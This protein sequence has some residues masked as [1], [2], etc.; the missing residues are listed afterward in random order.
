MNFMR[1]VLSFFIFAFFIVTCNQSSS[2][3]VNENNLKTYLLSE[4]KKYD[5]TYILQTFTFI[6]LD[7]ITLQDQY[8]QFINGMLDK[9]EENHIEIKRLFEE[10]KSN[11][12]MQRLSSDLSSN[13]YNNFKDNA[14]D[15]LKKANELISKDTILLKDIDILGKIKLTTD[16]IKPISYEA[17]CFYIIKKQDQSIQK[18]TAFIILDLDYN[19]LDRKEYKK[20]LNKLYR[21][22]SG[23]IY[24]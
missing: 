5:S 4:L 23:F 8:Y 20:Q 6:K 12:Q 18:D 15:Y 21:T 11:K 13:L 16:S 7:T 19:I 9:V 1:L 2:K 22:L 14:E 3:K 17:K 10:V 24:E